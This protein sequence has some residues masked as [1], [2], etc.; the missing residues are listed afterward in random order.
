MLYLTSNDGYDVNNSRK[1]CSGKVVL[2][3][4]VNPFRKVHACPNSSIIILEEPECSIVEQLPRRLHQKLLLCFR[5]LGTA[6]C[7]NRGA[8]TIDNLQTA[9]SQT[10][11]S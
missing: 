5:R 6:L 11:V 4:E 3:S 9:G 10:I 8:E 2:R 7:I 1:T